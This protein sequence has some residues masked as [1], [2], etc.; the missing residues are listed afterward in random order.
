MN[1]NQSTS[2]KLLLAAIDLMAD[3]GYDGTT[4]KE[5][6]LAAG[7]NE[8]TLFRHFGTK[9]KLLQ[10]AFNRYHYGQEMGKLFNE[11]LQGELHSDLLM[12]SRTYHKI[13][14]RNKKLISIAL[15]GSSNLPDEVLQEASRNPKYLKSLLTKYL[16]TMSEQGKV[17]TSNPELNALSFMWM[18]Y[19]AFISNLNAKEAVSDD[20]L[21]EFIEESVR[22]FARA[23]TP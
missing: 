6:A 23:L 7:V 10:A 9:E 16:T 20:S 14:S 15:K 19:G 3:K 22:L 21:D 13:M 11:A 12:L 5:I 17:V 4:T 18:N 1:S 8:V 2:D